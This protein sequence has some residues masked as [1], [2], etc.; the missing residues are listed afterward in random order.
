MTDLQ[1]TSADPYN[2]QRFLDA[3][4]STINQARSELVAGEK[5][6]HWMWFI[7]PQI[8]G[9]GSS[10]M[11]QRFAIGDL[12]EAIAY[13]EH[14][15]LGLRLRECTSLVNAVSSRPVSDIFG[16]PDDLKFHSSITLFAEAASGFGAENHVFA[17][18]LARYFKGQPD[19]ATLLL[20][21]GR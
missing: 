14:P 5:R 11:S 19:K 15:M 18:A 17:E 8:R 9:L 10:P 1:D 16:Y 20:L 7:F 21:N 13:L 12:Q 6:S 2:L 4:E 3:Q